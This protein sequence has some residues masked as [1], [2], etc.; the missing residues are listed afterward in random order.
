MAKD[1][2]IRFR[3]WIPGSGYNSAGDPV[4]G[5]Q[6]VVGVSNTTTTTGWTAA[7]EPF[8]PKDIGLST[9]DSITL[10]P[11]SAN[12]AA[13]LPDG[14]NGLTIEYDFTNQLVFYFTQVRATGVETSVVNGEA[15]VFRFDAIGD[16]A[17]APE[18]LP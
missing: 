16:S 10:V 11:V 14:T 5:K 3:Q 8:T 7:G 1:I 15:A 17:T 2:T 9:I 13:T 4:Q 12:D 18:L 6:R